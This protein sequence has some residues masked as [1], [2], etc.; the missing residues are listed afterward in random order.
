MRAWEFGLARRVQPSLMSILRLNLVLTYGIPPEFR[1]G[2][3][4]FMYAWALQMFHTWV[5]SA[6]YASGT[7]IIRQTPPTRD[8]GV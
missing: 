8:Q 4:L 6:A 5:D 3:H 1:G 7:L 2:A